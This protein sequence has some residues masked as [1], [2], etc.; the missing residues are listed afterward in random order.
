VRSVVGW[1][2]AGIAICFLAPPG[3]SVASL[4]LASKPPTV[5]R[6]S[7]STTT[8]TAAPAKKT[9]RDE[10]VDSLREKMYAFVGSLF[11]LALAFWRFP[12]LLKTSNKLLKKTNIDLWLVDLAGRFYFF[13]AVRANGRGNTMKALSRFEQGVR[14]LQ[15]AVD[16]G[17]R[18]D[19]DVSRT[20]RFIGDP[21]LAP[22]HSLRAWAKVWSDQT[23]AVDSADCALRVNSKDV[24]ARMA[25][26]WAKLK[27]NHGSDIAEA[28][29]DFVVAIEVGR[30]HESLNFW[31]QY[32]YA[33]VLRRRGEPEKAIPE[34]SVLLRHNWRGDE[35]YTGLGLADYALGDWQEAMNALS[36]AIAISPE[37]STAREYRA[38]TFLLLGRLD[39]AIDDCRVLIKR[40]PDNHQA[41]YTFGLAL[42][43]QSQNPTE[44]AV[45]RVDLLRR[46]AK[47]LRLAKDIADGKK[48]PLP[49]VSYRLSAVESELGNRQEAQRLLKEARNSATMSG[50]Q[51]RV[52][53]VV[54]LWPSVRDAVEMRVGDDIRATLEEALE[55]AR[56]KP[57]D[58]NAQYSVGLL[59]LALARDT[60]GL[61][62]RSDNLLDAG[63]YFDKAIQFSPTWAAPLYVSAWMHMQGGHLSRA[64]EDCDRAI[65]LDKN[66][67]DAYWLRA[68]IRRAIDS[69]DQAREDIDAALDLVDENIAQAVESSAASYATR[70]ALHLETGAVAEAIGDAQSALDLDESNLTARLVLSQALLK[71]AKYEAAL[72]QADYA[73]KIDPANADAHAARGVAH[74]HLGDAQVAIDAYTKALELKPGEP[75]LYYNRGLAHLIAWDKTGLKASLD[76]ADSDFQTAATKAGGG[77]SGNTGRAWVRY[78]QY[79]DGAPTLDAALTFCTLALEQDSLSAPAHF[80]RG[81]IMTEKGRY[82]DAK[83][84]FTAAIQ[85][86]LDAPDSLYGLA[87]AERLLGNAAVAIEDYTQAIN[88]SAVIGAAGW[89]IYNGRAGVYMDDRSYQKAYDDFRAALEDARKGPP[90]P[91]Q[92]ASLY[93]D[94]AWTCYELSR[95]E[96]MDNALKRGFELDP[97]SRDLHLQIGRVRVYCGR[98]DEAIAAYTTAIDLDPASSIGYVNRGLTRI[99]AGDLKA[100]LCDLDLAVEKNDKDYATWAERGWARARKAADWDKALSDIEKAIGLATS[101]PFPFNNRA[102]VRWWLRD[103]DGALEDLRKVLAMQAGPSI[104]RFR[105]RLRE[106]AVTWGATSEDWSHAVERRP[107]DFLVHLG[108]GISRCMAGDLVGAEEDLKKAIALNARSQDTEMLL[109]R[110][111]AERAVAT[112][113]Q[114]SR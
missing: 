47:Q 56:R 101:D 70:A 62:K 13:R 37:L 10:L 2:F 109:Q 88:K 33:E 16:E 81:W 46:A 59:Y 69:R 64:R 7:K 25:R 60:A 34:Y 36:A 91:S 50:R 102:L 44:D 6:T 52:P 39:E 41:Y 73:A 53:D 111:K 108:R 35:I 85:L 83:R 40:E 80:V 12:E 27:R 8:A 63:R 49:D 1:L 23:A 95:D 15:W 42:Y 38:Y 104:N 99:Y 84:D 45:K 4:V 96:E 26:G 66:L 17:R 103:H 110:V 86:G 54:A 51:A 72:L 82:D 87:N 14:I 92:Y 75:T 100:A 105:A 90:T 11:L 93:S 19:A 77:A 65:A 20:E 43:Q 89:N 114:T 31:A 57:A 58:A 113:G 107:T 98:Y 55:L 94:F 48:L 9:L 24:N 28:E 97:Q 21:R 61:G 106:D 5:A 79:R 30:A 32:G 29:S 78:F 71:Q 68:Q 74:Y 67:A 22:L 18:R 76:S 112:L 3:S